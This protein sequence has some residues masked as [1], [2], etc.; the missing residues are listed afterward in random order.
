MFS[1]NI[2]L[3]CF[4]LDVDTYKIILVKTPQLLYPMFL[5]MLQKYRNIVCKT[6]KNALGQHHNRVSFTLN[7]V[8][9]NL[10][11]FLGKH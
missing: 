5:I 11:D 8:H 3:C 6:F 2:L 4:T 9:I 7:A 10:E 1:A